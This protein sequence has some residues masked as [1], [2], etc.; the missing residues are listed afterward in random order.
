M[1][2][3]VCLLQDG[4]TIGLPRSR[5]LPSIGP[6]V[7]EL[8]VRDGEHNWRVIYRIDD[9]LILVVSSFAKKTQR[10]PAEAIRLARKRLRDHDAR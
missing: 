3:G 1:R 4:E 5:P 10:T 6:R 8:R 2:S 7:H 9:D